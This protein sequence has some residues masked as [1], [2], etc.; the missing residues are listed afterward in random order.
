MYVYYSLPLDRP[1]H[2][3]IVLP[4]NGPW[5]MILSPCFMVYVWKQCL[6]LGLTCINL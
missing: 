6:L 3:C 1:G 5:C 2:V 4:Y